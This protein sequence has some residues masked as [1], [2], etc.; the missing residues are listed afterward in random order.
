M[1]LTTVAKVRGIASNLSSLED[2]TIEMYIDD[3]VLELEDFRYDEKYQE[4]LERYMAAHLGT[5][6]K[7][8]PTDKMLGPMRNMYPNR[9]GQEEL[10]LTEYGKEVLRILRK[11]NGPAMVVF[12]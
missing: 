2:S 11:C 4:K 8:K 9:T 5:L 7:P 10:K 12:S 6:D 3:A 1:A